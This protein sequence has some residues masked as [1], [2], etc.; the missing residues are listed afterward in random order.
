MKLAPSAQKEFDLVIIG[1]GPS[2]SIAAHWA[3]KLKLKACIIDKSFFPRDKVCGDCLPPMTYQLLQELNLSIH[4]C[5]S[6]DYQLVEAINVA[7][8]SELI[9]ADFSKNNCFNFNRRGFDNFLWNAIP[10]GVDKLEGYS[11]K[12]LKFNQK[13]SK[14]E[15]EISNDQSTKTLFSKYIIGADGANS[16]VRKSSGLFS[17]FNMNFTKA[18][19]AYATTA[20]SGQSNDLLYDNSASVSYKWKFPVNKQKTNIGFY[21]S[22]KEDSTQQNNKKDI[23]TDLAEK[24]GV[25]IDWD[26]Y[27]GAPIPTFGKLTTIFSTNGAFLVGDAAGLSDPIMGHGIDLGMLSGKIAVQSIF[28]ASNK[29]NFRRQ[30][31]ASKIYNEFIQKEF[32]QKFNVMREYVENQ[33]TY[34]LENTL[35][36]TVQNAIKNR[37]IV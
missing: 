31:R 5:N 23:L 29:I 9:T 15:V 26:T 6:E 8:P 17:D 11:I 19:R 13:K 27:K 10:E 16:W 7:S 1:G 30:K 14:Y 21:F 22:M 34:Q 24:H 20:E 28:R 35:K 18:V 3:A 2:G 36:L 32:V 4:Q 25:E 33:T 12:E 37:N